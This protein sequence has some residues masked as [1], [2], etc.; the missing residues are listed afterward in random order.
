[1]WWSLEKEK[2][3]DDE[4][5]GYICKEYSEKKGNFVVNDTTEVGHKMKGFL[6]QM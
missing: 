2:I 3:T 4:A 6:D 5:L 1:M